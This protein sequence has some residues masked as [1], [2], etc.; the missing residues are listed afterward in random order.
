MDLIRDSKRIRK[1]LL[2]QACRII[3]AV[4]RAKHSP[5]NANRNLNDAARHADKWSKLAASK[6]VEVDAS[7]YR[8]MATVAASLRQA[9]V[10][11]DHRQ[12]I[13]L[14]EQAIAELRAVV[15]NTKEK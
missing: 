6:N 9:A 13:G 1:S 12:R 14:A 5:A 11:K 15:R 7:H 8:R 2:D 4:E 3:K 10:I